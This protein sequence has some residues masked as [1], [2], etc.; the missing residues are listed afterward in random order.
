MKELATN[1]C[2]IFYVVKY[3][4]YIYQ[5]IIIFMSTK[6]PIQWLFLQCHFILNDIKHYLIF[7]LSRQKYLNRSKSTVPL[8]IYMPSICAWLSNLW[9]WLYFWLHSWQWSEKR[10]GVDELRWSFPTCMIL[11][12]Y[13]FLPS[14][15]KNKLQGSLRQPSRLIIIHNYTLRPIHQLL[16]CLSLAHFVFPKFL[17]TFVWYQTICPREALDI[18]IVHSTSQIYNCI[19]TS[20][21]APAFLTA[22]F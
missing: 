6:S 2:W 17:K 12:C 14:K 19:K 15:E 9:Q 7:L 21:N 13:D 8:I 5:H 18:I 20:Q 22:I 10:I 11:W 4:Y 3:F 1:L 16:I